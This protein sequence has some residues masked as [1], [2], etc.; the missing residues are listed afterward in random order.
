[1]SVWQI[2]FARGAIAFIMMMLKINTNAKKE[3]WD[4]W[5]KIETHAIPFLIFRCFQA[6]ASLFIMFVCV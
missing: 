1:M 2:S 5:R 3:L 6:G 4:V